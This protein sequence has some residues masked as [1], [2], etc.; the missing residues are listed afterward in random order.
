MTEV[1]TPVL[2]SDHKLIH[3]R[4]LSPETDSQWLAQYGLDP[5][6]VDYSVLSELASR[7]SDNLFGREMGEEVFESVVAAR[8]AFFTAIGLSPETHEMRTVRKSNPHFVP[9]ST[10]VETHRIMADEGLD[11]RRIIN[12][13][14]I[15]IHYGA[16][17]MQRRIDNLKT[18]GLDP[19]RTTTISPK[20]I[21]Y[22]AK[23]VQGKVNYL[24][25]LGLDPVRVLRTYPQAITF[26]QESIRE[27]VDALREAG[28]DPVSVIDSHSGVIG[29]SSER[30]RIY[31]KKIRQYAVL[32]RWH[33]SVEELIEKHAEILSFNR[34]KLRLLVRIA[35]TDLSVRR[36][37]AT[38]GQVVSGLINPVEN[39]VAAYRE[40]F[41]IG[42]TDLE[43][44]AMRLQRTNKGN[45]AKRKTGAEEAIADGF[46]PE[47]VVFQYR[48]YRDQKES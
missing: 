9:V 6:T 14:P 30:I 48:R 13:N 27:K 34:Q 16:A 25:A 47:R 35:A 46:V 39:Y 28:L 2:D 26:S 42:D 4:Y 11:C 24:R 29:L 33:G 21:G 10:F 3:R 15:V 40:P 37:S 44:K 41:V 32:L 18:L 45:K 1:A 38:V 31:V 36:R 7:G 12:A 5:S 8:E 22:S 17:G 43:K 19:V 23:G 20:I